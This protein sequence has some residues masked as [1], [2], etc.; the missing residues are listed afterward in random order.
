MEKDFIEIGSKRIPLSDIK[1][2][3][4]TTEQL[5]RT[6]TEKK[7]RNWFVRIILLLTNPGFVNEPNEVVVSRR[8]P[9]DVMIIKTF[10]GVEYRFSKNEYVFDIQEKARELNNY[11]Q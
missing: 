8:I 4:I 3:E 1:N 10:Q 7:K 2:Y 11:L 5:K 6:Y 9:F